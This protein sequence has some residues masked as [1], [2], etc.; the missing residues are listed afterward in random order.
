M[1]LPRAAR[2]RALVPVA[3][4]VL[5]A[6]L[7]PALAEETATAPCGAGNGSDQLAVGQPRTHQFMTPM[8]TAPELAA[9]RD[10]TGRLVTPFRTA[11]FEHT[12]VSAPAAT[13]VL[14][15]T[16]SWPV[17]QMDYDLYVLGADGAV[18]ASSD[19]Q[20]ATDG[21]G[22]KLE[23]ELAHC[24]AFTVEVRNWAGTFAEKPLNLTLS[25]V[26]G[27]EQL[28]DAPAAVADT[29][30]RLWLDATGPGNVASVP[31]SGT[32]NQSGAPVGPSVRKDRPTTGVP[33]GH[34]R[35]AG[36]R[37]QYKN[38]LVPWW[39]A[40]LTAP[41]PVV[42]DGSAL[43]WVSSPTLAQGG[44]LYVDLYLDGAL[45]SSAK[46]A[47]ALIGRDPTPVRVTF[48]GLE[49]VDPVT[50]VGLQVA[51]VP[52]VAS[53]GPGNPA[54]AE[55]TVWFGSVQFPSRVTLP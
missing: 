5:A 18:L 55:D 48:P 54:D 46:V 7:A 11:V 14:S 35:V 24:Q 49:A 28:P 9:T 2:R 42:G 13:G 17:D 29:A 1:S 32:A 33:N 31:G 21:P 6:G 22:E 52:A 38:L 27:E 40:P 44:T 26:P 53:S 34:A 41:R 3:L 16:L 37:D 4:A 51:T 50:T 19:A 10:A 30:T 23:V 8:G 36:F 25:M 39:E 45:A 15:A 20:N 12:A 47:G 43:V